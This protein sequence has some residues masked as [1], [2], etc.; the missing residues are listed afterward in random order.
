MVA[1]VALDPL[2]LKVGQRLRGLV[3]QLLEFRLQPFDLLL[4]QALL[5]AHH[6]DAF[7]GLR[8]DFLAQLGGVGPDRRRVRGFLLQQ[9]L[10]LGVQLQ[11]LA[12]SRDVHRPVRR[13]VH[14]LGLDGDRP[15]GQRL[16]SGV[17]HADFA[18]LS[19][20]ASQD[21][22]GL[23][24]AK[25]VQRQRLAVVARHLDDGRLGVRG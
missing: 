10:A 21:L 9:Q 8:D 12:V 19:A 15:A 20:H 16:A 18:G 1:L 6:L 4:V 23:A 2:L 11:Q 13:H 3:G 17:V 22:S 5:L 25:G 7:L 24:Q 14:G